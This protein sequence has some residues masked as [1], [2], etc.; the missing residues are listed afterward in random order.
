[1]GHKV[2]R[3]PQLQQPAVL[4]VV[5]ALALLALALVPLAEHR[6][7]TH[8][9]T[10]IMIMAIFAMSLDLLVGYGGL[11]SLGHALFF[12]VSGYT[13]ALLTPATE[14]ASVWLTL[15]AAL[16]VAA[17]AALLV[18]ALVL[19][20]SGV[21][22]IM[23]TLAFAQ[24]VFFF[25]HDSRHLGGSDGKYINFKPTVSLAGWEPLDLESPVQR[26]YVVLVL[27]VACYWLLRVLLRAPFGQVLIGC[28]VNEARMR[29]LGFATFRY[30]LAAF[31]IAGTLAGLAGYLHGVQDGVVNPELLSWHQSG[32][33]LVMVILGGMGIPAGAAIGAAALMLL[34]LGF[35]AWTKHW[36]LLLGGFIVAVVFLLPN[37]IAGLLA[38]RGGDDGS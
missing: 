6:F 18:G 19:R 4:R 16:G 9:F 22:F 13:L 3:A 12:G 7:Y 23:V 38:R 5:L 21:Y 14:P 33:A 2:S 35:S 34:E 36:Q 1:V 26:Y 25:V 8:F 28:R 15:P 20:T 29:S 32:H 10:K 31:V 11:V 24:M 37:G 30:Q 27:L 17:L